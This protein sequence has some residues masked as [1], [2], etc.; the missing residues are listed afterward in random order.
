M[1][2]KFAVHIEFD[3]TLEAEKIYQTLKNLVRALGSH[4]KILRTWTVEETNV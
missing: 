1:K 2:R 4:P 3:H